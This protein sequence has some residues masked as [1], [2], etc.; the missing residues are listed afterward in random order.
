MAHHSDAPRRSPGAARDPEA[1]AGALRRW[2]G[3]HGLLAYTVLACGISW[4]LLISGFL[5]ARAGTLDPDGALV[6]VLIQVAA[7]GP[8]IAA[9]VVLALTRGRRGLGELARS[10]VRWRVHPVWYA[11]VLLAVP[12]LGLAATWVFHPAAMAASLA[13]NWSLLYTQLPL[14]VLSI[15][16]FTGLAE[17]P[18]W[19][20]YAQPTANQRHR[21]L[22]AALIVSV[23]WALWHLPNALFGQGA[24]ETLA[25]LLATVVNGFV[26]AWVYN[27]TAGSVL[28]VMLLHGAQNATGGLVLLL[29]EGSA[30]GPTRTGYYLISALVF[31]ALMV[32]VTV[33]TRGRLGLPSPGAHGTHRSG[34]TP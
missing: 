4:S 21:P 3:R 29:F 23:I 20:G 13:Q 25:H 15:A 6:W 18:G 26:L 1:Q 19:R 33:R 14:G 2:T 32:V 12:L 16:L 30:D 28:L 9:V 5:G 8:L 34:G 17:E 10:I 31:G 27:A 24:V 11:F 7:G 22:T